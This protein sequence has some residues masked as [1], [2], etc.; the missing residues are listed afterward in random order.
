LK[1]ARY[2]KDIRLIETAW[3]HSIPQGSGK[4]E[5]SYFFHKASLFIIYIFI[6]KTDKTNNKDV[7]AIPME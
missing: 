6:T 5:H 1:H 7:S 4:V 3:Q 2:R